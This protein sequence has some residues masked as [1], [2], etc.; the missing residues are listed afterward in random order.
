M[1]KLFLP[2]FCVMCLSIAVCLA[3]IILMWDQESTSAIIASTT[4]KSVGAVVGPLVTIPFLNDQ[5]FESDHSYLVNSTSEYTTQVHIPYIIAACVFMPVAANFLVCYL[6]CR[7]YLPAPQAEPNQQ[8]DKASDSYQQSSDRFTTFWFT[9]VTGGFLFFLLISASVFA[10]HFFPSIAVESSLAMSQQDA[11]I[12]ATVFFIARAAG[13]FLST[14]IARCISASLILFG[15]TIISLIACLFLFFFGLTSIVSY[16]FLLIT[17]AL[18][19]GPIQPLITVWVNKYIRAD[20][21]VNAVL[22]L[23]MSLGI[24]TGTYG[25]GAVFESYGTTG[26]LYLILIPNIAAVLVLVPLLLYTD[27][28][29]RKT[30]YTKL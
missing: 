25:S 4:A 9:V 15:S 22:M 23:G 12:L 20:G 1:V 10:M 17:F 21:T 19:S 3:L 14:F 5:I 30:D 16:C 13:R 29:T 26:W 24:F 27:S 6:S 2:L 8:D 18:T 7:Q 11:A 28:F